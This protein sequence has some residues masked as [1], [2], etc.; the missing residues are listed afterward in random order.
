MTS[1]NGLRRPSLLLFKCSGNQSTVR[2]HREPH[3]GQRETKYATYAY[4][5]LGGD[6]ITN[7]HQLDHSG[8]HAPCFL[9]VTRTVYWTICQILYPGLHSPKSKPATNI[10]PL[11]L[12]ITLDYSRAH[13]QNP[14]PFL[15]FFP[16]S[17]SQANMA[18]TVSIL[19]GGILATYLFL[20]FLLHVTQDAREPPTIVTGIPFLSPL[21]GMMREKSRF[22]LRL[23]LVN[24]VEFHS[25]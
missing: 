17:T 11:W 3:N 21:I 5:W 4:A 25:V 19:C 18:P 7:L 24:F 23:R 13:L 6:E 22:Y 2:W 12:T 9:S 10:V 15:F 1:R 8:P 14:F 16:P 20:R